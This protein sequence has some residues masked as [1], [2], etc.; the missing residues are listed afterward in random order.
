M[1]ASI[2]PSWLAISLCT[3]PGSTNREEKESEWLSR[4]PCSVRLGS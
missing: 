3:N 2:S 4:P 1:R